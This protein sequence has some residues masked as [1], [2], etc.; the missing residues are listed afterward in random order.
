MSLS[1][2][3][4]GNGFEEAERRLTEMGENLSLLRYSG[5]SVTLPTLALGVAGE[6]PARH[7]YTE[8]WN[9]LADEFQHGNKEAATI[10]DLLRETR[11][12]YKEAEGAAVQGVLNAVTKSR[13]AGERPAEDD[14]PWDGREE[15]PSFSDSLGDAAMTIAPWLAGTA[16]ALSGAGLRAAAGHWNVEV[17][18]R[19]HS[20]MYNIDRLN[21]RAIDK[22]AK[23]KESLRR[24]SG[25]WEEPLRDPHFERHY[26]PGVA[27]AKDRLA[28]AKSDLAKWSAT[29][30]RNLKTTRTFS[31]A[32]VAAG[33][34]WASLIIPSDETLDQAVLGW[35]KLA[36]DLG[37]I[38]GHD[39]AAV[40]EAVLSSW[41]GASSSDAARR[42][43]EFI[44]AGNVLTERVARLSRALAETV[45]A[46]K[47][48]HWAAMLFSTVA[49]AAIV[50]FGQAGK[51]NPQARM[52]TEFLGSRLTTVI[53][54]IAGI[55]P[56]LSAVGA[57]WWNLRDIDV[58]VKLGDR[59]ITGFR[60]A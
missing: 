52:L 59:E 19:R 57:H 43:L 41:Q 53:L 29:T 40:R 48:V 4:G 51:L 26:F 58:S 32:T 42:L 8:I 20:L 18:G 56:S 23:M 45:D 27:D 54:L 50:A 46:L 39:T 22:E 15:Y 9:T 11:R 44:A 2:D 10:G 30:E 3:L 47:G 24:S 38:F 12:T 6:W 37:E 28:Q 25:V 33:L 35:Q 49:G 21:E 7:Q 17:S 60:R 36:W 1:F 16:G 14:D 13:A 5:N 55:A 31:W 34:A